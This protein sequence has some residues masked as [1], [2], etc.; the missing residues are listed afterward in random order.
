M[1]KLGEEQMAQ[2]P[3]SNLLHWFGG[4]SDLESWLGGRA[5][6]WGS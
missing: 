2:Y 1:Q 4:S 6:A 3:F 5:S